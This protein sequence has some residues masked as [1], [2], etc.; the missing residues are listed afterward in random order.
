LDNRLKNAHDIPGITSRKNESI[1]KYF[2][3]KK[4]DLWFGVFII[5][6]NRRIQAKDTS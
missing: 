1:R 4:D 3:A 2:H 5:E 6:A